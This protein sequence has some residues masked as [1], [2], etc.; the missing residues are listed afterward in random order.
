MGRGGLPGG[1]EP[2]LVGLLALEG[3]ISKEQGGQWERHICSEEG[4]KVPDS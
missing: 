3:L 4:K 1:G 2:E